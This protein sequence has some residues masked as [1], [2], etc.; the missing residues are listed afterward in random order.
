MLDAFKKR[1]IN[2]LIDIYKQ[3]KL[4]KITKYNL[5]KEHIRSKIL[6]EDEKEE[7]IHQAKQSFL[8]NKSKLELKQKI[9][10]KIKIITGSK[11]ASRPTPAPRPIPTPSKKALLIGIN[12]TGTR[13][14]LKGCI[15]DVNDVSNYL[16][17]K[18]FATKIITDFTTPLKPYRSTILTEFK[19]LLQKS[20]PGDQLCFM[21][22]GHGSNRPDKD[23]N[24]VSGT[25]QTICPLD[26][27]SIVDDELKIIINQY[28]P[29][30]VTLFA[31]FDSCYSGS[32]LDLKYQYLDSLNYNEATI[33]EKVSQTKG[34]VFMIS[35]CTDKQTSADAYIN[36]KYNG[37][38]TWSFL[39]VLKQSIPNITWG[40]LVKTMRDTLKSNN[41]SQIP[42]F[43]CGQAT[44][45]DEPIRCI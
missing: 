40:N 39:Q 4:S 33:N 29:A 17:G 7:Q 28:L 43:S 20:K 41:Y 3:Y 9:K 19:N 10:E 36:N 21:F 12:Y 34:N 44:N 2:R 31:L 14:Q 23:N 6:S 11:P 27:R 38:L 24:E 8:K 35:G 30:G 37:A 16:R 5:T 13:N 45:I 42:Q 26:L 22:S 18:G 25:D 15:N 1:E 32:V